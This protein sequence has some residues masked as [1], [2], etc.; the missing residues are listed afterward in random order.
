MILTGIYKHRVELLLHFKHVSLFTQHF[1]NRRG[2]VDDSKYIPTNHFVIENL[3]DVS[4]IAHFLETNTFPKS[5]KEVFGV[6]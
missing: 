2:S 3:K 1:I 4:Y 5:M 6:L